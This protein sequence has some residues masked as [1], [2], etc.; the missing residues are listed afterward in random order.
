[1]QKSWSCLG[2]LSQSRGILQWKGLEWSRMQRQC[3]GTLVPWMGA[4]NC[5]GP[6]PHSLDWW[7][8]SRLLE[9]LWFHWLSSR[10]PPCRSFWLCLGES[11][12]FDSSWTPLDWLGRG[13]DYLIQWLLCSGRKWQRWVVSKSMHS[14]W[15]LLLDYYVPKWLLHFVEL[16]LVKCRLG[17]IG[18][19]I[20]K[21]CHCPGGPSIL[22]REWCIVWRH[23][24]RHLSCPR[25]WQG[26][27]SFL[28][29][30]PQL[31]LRNPL[32]LSSW[33]ELSW[34]DHFCL[35]RLWCLGELV[36]E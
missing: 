14:H 28:L 20:G 2:C 25:D 5:T 6:C 35:T 32:P 9:G 12:W 21:F 4:L 23:R 34:M 10:Q 36:L 27:R 26:S 18:H 33:V 31:Q 1:M 11:F 7:S 19:W 13:G 22:L 30:C 24:A 29:V 15:R 17:V 16:L 8:G 3:L